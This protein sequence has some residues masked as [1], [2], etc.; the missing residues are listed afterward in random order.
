MIKE[1]IFFKRPQDFTPTLPS[2]LSLPVNA[3]KRMGTSHSLGIIMTKPRLCG[4]R[5]KT[6][7]FR[8]NR[9]K[10]SSH[11]RLESTHAHNAF[12]DITIIVNLPSGQKI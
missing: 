5:V 6:N 9:W 1:F 12:K 4:Y 3:I 8:W 11:V 10:P 7:G 2:N